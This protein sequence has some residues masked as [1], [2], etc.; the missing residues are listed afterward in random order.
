MSDQFFLFFFFFLYSTM[1]FFSDFGKAYNRHKKFEEVSNCADSMSQPDFA[2]LP[3]SEL[4]RRAGIA[5]A[6][7]VCPPFRRLASFFGSFCF[8]PNLPL[9]NKHDYNHIHD[10]D[11]PLLS[12]K[13]T[14]SDHITHIK[15]PAPWRK[16]LC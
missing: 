8:C 6:S 12:N 14:N 11:H 3:F 9:T 16:H 13:P 4:L 1:A 15:K 7:I 5:E 10:R 2:L